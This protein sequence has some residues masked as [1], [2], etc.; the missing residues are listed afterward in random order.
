MKILVYKW[1]IYP[2]DTI[3]DTLKKQGHQVDVLAFPIINPFEDKNFETIFLA[4]LTN[5]YD[6]IFSMNY[7]AVIGRICAQ[8]RITYISWT[9]DSPLISLTDASSQEETNHI[10]L[11]DRTGYEKLLGK[12]AKSV[13]YLPLAGNS[14]E[15]SS[16]EREFSYDVSFVGNL[17][18]KN[19]YDEMCLYLPDYLCGYMDAAIEAQKNISGGYILPEMLD[20]EIL[21]KLNEY[22]HF[23]DGSTSVENLRLH[24]ATTVL[25][26]KVSADERCLALNL[27]VRHHPVHLFTTSQGNQLCNVTI[28]P[29]VDYHTKMPKVFAVSK[30]N[31]NLTSPNI[32]NGIPLRVFDI[33]SAGGFL[34]TDYRSEVCEQFEN[35]VDLVVFEGMEDLVKKV[36]YYLSHPQERMAIAQ[37]GREK[38]RSQHLYEHRLQEM[39]NTVFGHSK[40]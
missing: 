29:A 35:G 20:D 9:C 18:D 14:T 30:I 8:R 5:D 17:Y 27:L 3:I 13:Y 26:H 16:I 28:H 31:L 33:L 1:D 15:A 10:F 22:T 40:P 36:D 25:A 32:E 39:L 2:Y 34:L 24:F 21:L 38:I 4:Q 19:R 23:A 7:F 6:F 37:N 11:F 12:G